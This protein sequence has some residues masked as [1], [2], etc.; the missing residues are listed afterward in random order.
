MRFSIVGHATLYVETER[1]N[2]LV[3]PWLFGS[4]YWRSWWHYP[5]ISDVPDSWLAPEYLYLTH[6]HFDHFHACRRT[7]RRHPRSRSGNRLHGR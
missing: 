1:A 7:R 5:P 3:D 6:H 4:C 2:L